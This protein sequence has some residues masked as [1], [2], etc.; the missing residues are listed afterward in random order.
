MVLICNG[1]SHSL[2]NVGEMQETV[3]DRLMRLVT[4]QQ[5][6]LNAGQAEKLLDF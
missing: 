4:D 2:L 3:Q 1:G 6:L 5:I